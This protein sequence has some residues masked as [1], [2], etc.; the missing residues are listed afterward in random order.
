MLHDR[1]F[2]NSTYNQHVTEGTRKGFPISAL[3]LHAI[4]LW[5]SSFAKYNPMEI[6]RASVVS[7]QLKTRGI[8][9]V[10]KAP[11]LLSPDLSS[12]SP[13]LTTLS[14]NLGYLTYVDHAL[15]NYST[16]THLNLDSNRLSYVSLPISKL[17][18]TP[19]LDTYRSFRT[20]EPLCSIFKP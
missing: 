19:C 5:S 1:S 16:L 17:V 18:L 2:V 13:S 9:K 10:V 12:L 15:A 20:R 7:E 3:Q 4:H 8:K 11:C 6:E 14:L